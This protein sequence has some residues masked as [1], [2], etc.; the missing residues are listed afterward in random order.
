[1]S[2]SKLL[3]STEH[4]PSANLGPEG[5]SNHRADHAIHSPKV[6]LERIRKGNKHSPAM[7]RLSPAN[8]LQASWDAPRKASNALPSQKLLALEM[9]MLS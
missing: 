6:R 5:K 7:P 1:M 9:L 8:A 3:N 2:A 4:R